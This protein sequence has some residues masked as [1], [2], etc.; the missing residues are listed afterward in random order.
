MALARINSCLLI[1]DARHYA[2]P[3]TR[4]YSLDLFENSVDRVILGKP[5][6]P[7]GAS[8]FGRRLRAALNHLPRWGLARHEEKAF[9]FDPAVLQLS[10]GTSLSGY[11]QS[12]RYLES[13][14]AKL[15]AEL[16][17]LVS[18]SSWYLDK[19][20]QLEAD[21]W[22]GVHVRL[23]DYTAPSISAH[24]GLISSGFYSR[25]VDH[26]RQLRGVEKEIAFSDQPIEASAI[27][28][29]AGINHTMITPPAEATPLENLLLMSSANALVTA[30]STFSWW[31]AWVGDH[32]SRPVICPRPWFRK[33]LIREADLLLPN[34]LSLGIDSN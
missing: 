33:S 7:G 30:N 2:S 10:S 20:S 5:T 18:P 12:W 8:R 24:H 1:V 26:C 3:G 13:V 4:N 25:A 23:G 22:I 21:S 17:N 11:F 9:T 31:A 19:A 6:A 14:K 27:L 16:R 29:D 32:E 34:W 15:R 28:H